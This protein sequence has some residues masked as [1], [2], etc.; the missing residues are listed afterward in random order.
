[1]IVVAAAVTG[2]RG[3]KLSSRG[4]QT[5]RDLSSEVVFS[6]EREDESRSDEVKP[7]LA[8]AAPTDGWEIPRCL[9]NSG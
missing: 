9:C 2:G 3:A 4:A 8:R 7:S 6:T 5:P 1:M